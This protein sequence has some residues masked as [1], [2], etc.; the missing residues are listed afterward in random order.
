[1]EIYETRRRTLR[2]L[3]L[4]LASYH[5]YRDVIQDFA[6]GYQMLRL[7]RYSCDCR[8]LSANF[9]LC[10]SSRCCPLMNG[11]YKVP[12]AIIAPVWLEACWQNRYPRHK[13][14]NPSFLACATNI[15]HLFVDALPRLTS[16]R[17]DELP[18]VGTCL[19]TTAM[20]PLV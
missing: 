7:D 8:S 1:M 17:G 15:S 6:F 12:V 4:R 5:R 19:R 16:T 10:S 20:Q 3:L 11:F 9:L 18:I 14:S 2:Y 13:P